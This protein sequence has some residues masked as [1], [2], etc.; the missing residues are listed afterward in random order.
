M[1][2]AA[3]KWAFHLASLA[4]AGG[5]LYWLIARQDWSALARIHDF[6]PLMLLLAAGAGAAYW[7]VRIRRWQW[8]ASLE[9]QKISS[10]LAARSMLAGLGV[11]LLTPLRGGEVVRPMFLPAGCRLKLAGWVVIE[12]VFDLSAVLTFCLLG[13]P[14]L[15]QQGILERAGLPAAIWMIAAALLL[16]AALAGPLLVL[17]RPRRLWALLERLLPG[18]ATQLAQV[19]LDRRGFGVFYATSLLAEALS[20]LAVF[21]CLSSLGEISPLLVFALSPVVMLNNLVP[22]TPGGVGVREALAVLVLGSVWKVDDAQQRV[23]AAYLVN[24]VIVLLIPAVIGVVMAWLAGVV[25]HRAK[26][27]ETAAAPAAEK[28]LAGEKN[29]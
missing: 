5:I 3:K 11:G 22:A 18:K 28:S 20:I 29:V 4:L 17:M 9:G 7:A 10:G 6:Q 8:M 13:L 26:A 14:Y 23:L 2:A 19:R 27:V 21:L 15:W 1:R 24:F 16:A 12:R 25:G